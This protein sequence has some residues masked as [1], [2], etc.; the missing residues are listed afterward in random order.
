M[1]SGDIVIMS[2]ESRLCYHAVPRILPASTK[3][4]T[5]CDNDSVTHNTDG[6]LYMKCQDV[7]FWQ[8]FNSYIDTARLNINVRQVLR[9]GQCSLDDE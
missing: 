7:I 2:N 3:P 5:N 1:E 8:P 4:W 6:D 9:P